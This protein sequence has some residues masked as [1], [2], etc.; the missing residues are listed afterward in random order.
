MSISA[1][2]FQIKQRTDTKS[3]YVFRIRALY[4]LW[5]RYPKNCTHNITGPFCKISR[6]KT[7]LYFHRSRCRSK[8]GRAIIWVVAPVHLTLL[9]LYDSRIR[10]CFLRH[11]QTLF[12]VNAINTF[13]LVFF[14]QTVA[15]TFF[16][17]YCLVW[18]VYRSRMKSLKDF[19]TFVF[20]NIT[21]SHKI[22][23]SNEFHINHDYYKRE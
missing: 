2:L 5:L 17:F 21:R 22:T 8:D 13:I 10:P 18:D 23:P 19:S 20:I 14:Y 12:S 1:I 6:F 11:S 4:F 15:Q 7:I 9:S 3:Y 16:I